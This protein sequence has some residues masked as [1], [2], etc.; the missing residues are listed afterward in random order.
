MR[1]ILLQTDI[2]SPYKCWL[3]SGIQMLLWNLIYYVEWRYLFPWLDRVWAQPQVTL[4]SYPQNW[5]SLYLDWNDQNLSALVHVGFEDLKP[6]C[7]QY[8]QELLI[9]HLECINSNSSL[10]FTLPKVQ[11]DLHEKIAGSKS[12]FFTGLLWSRRRKASFLQALK[13]RM[14]ALRAR[15]RE[16]ILLGDLNISPAPLDSCEPGFSSLLFSLH[17]LL[18]LPVEIPKSCSKTCFTNQPDFKIEAI[19]R[20]SFA[21]EKQIFIWFENLSA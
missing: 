16:I 11:F 9:N 10:Y 1:K 12:I 18:F 21:I 2:V 6:G 17:Q 15:G 20:L 14:E 5:A 13:I 4:T 3:T 8:L 7:W 19:L